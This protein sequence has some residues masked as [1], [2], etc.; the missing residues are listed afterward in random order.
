MQRLYLLLELSAVG[1]LFDGDFLCV[2][3]PRLAMGEG[4]GETGAAGFVVLASFCSVEELFRGTFLSGSFIMVDEGPIWVNS[5]PF[6]QFEGLNE[7]TR[8]LI[9][10]VV[11][12]LP[13]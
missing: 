2:V 6:L 5:L 4:D 13:A 1:V 9:V 3:A 7:Y 10:F 12:E 11:V 8:L